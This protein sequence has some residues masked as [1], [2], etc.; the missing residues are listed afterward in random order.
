M[1]YRSAEDRLNPVAPPDTDETTLGG[2]TTLHGRAAGF[3]GADGSPYTVA[4]EVD[5]DDAGNYAGYLV[6]VRWANGGSAIMGHV[7]TGDLVTAATEQE[8]RSA[9]AALP[10]REVKNL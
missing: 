1:Q 3:E 10:L 7:E 2:Y 9:L 6:F 4:I 5:P 8:A